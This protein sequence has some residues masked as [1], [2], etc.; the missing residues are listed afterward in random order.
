[1]SKNTVA[2]TDASFDEQVIQSEQPVLVDV[3]AP[4]CGPCRMIGPSIDELALEYQGRAKVVKLNVDENP[5]T[6]GRYHVHSIPTL[7][8][9]KGGKVVEQQA[10]AVP[11]A[12]IARLI[13][14]Q[15]AGDRS[16]A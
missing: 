2:V 13:D 15:L 8:V 10:G 9:F 6:A 16:P 12:V 11:K 5:E 1:M 3:W 14:S 7:L 4:W